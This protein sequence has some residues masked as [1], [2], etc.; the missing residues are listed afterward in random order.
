MLNAIREGLQVAG[1]QDASGGS[2]NDE[3][4]SP[5]MWVAFAGDQPMPF[6]TVDESGHRAGRQPKRRT[7]SIYRDACAGGRVQRPQSGQI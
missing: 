5:V 4:S 7:E 6:E 2:E 3:H 1:A